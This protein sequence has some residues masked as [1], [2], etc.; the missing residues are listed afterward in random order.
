M[1]T[2]A[3][4]GKLNIVANADVFVIPNM[5]AKISSFLDFARDGYRQL[6]NKIC[7]DNGKSFNEDTDYLVETW[8]CS[9]ELDS[10]NIADHGFSVKVD[11]STVLYFR[12]DIKRYIPRCSYG[13]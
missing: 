6:G 10:D 2:Y 5:A 3:A 9:K 4:D 12:G 1:Y 7:N 11:D 8:M 13:W